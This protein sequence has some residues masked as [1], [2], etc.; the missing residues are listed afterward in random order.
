MPTQ[1]EIKK[2]R[3]PIPATDIIIEYEENGVPGNVLIE[4]NNKTYGIDICGGFAE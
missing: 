2:F 3:N 1:E 4:R